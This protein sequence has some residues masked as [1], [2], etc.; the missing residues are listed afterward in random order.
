MK[1]LIATTNPGKFKELQ[2]GLTS[3]PIKTYS[4]TDLSITS[5]FDEPDSTIQDI[6]EK[7]AKFYF[8]LSK[9]PTI[10]D[11]SGIEVDALK[12][13]LGAKTRRWGA[14]RNATDQE[15]I[16]YFLEALKNTPE[17]KRTARFQTTISFFDGFE[18]YNFNGNSE[19]TITKNLE[20]PINPG[21]PLSS[22][23]KPI[24]FKKVYS[25]LTTEEKNKISHR[26]KALGKL[27]PF[28]EQY[29]DS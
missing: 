29:L 2:K 23:F 25:A 11:D 16:D 13:Q 17:Q 10:A 19:G 7:K 8:D 5:D 14:G 18:N 26:G 15:W 22:V 12:G 3:L 4:L 28:L 27:V 9:M 20:A 6:A 21:Q 1:L 24:G